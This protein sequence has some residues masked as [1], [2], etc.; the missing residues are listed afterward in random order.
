MIVI[1]EPGIG[2]SRLL[3]EFAARQRRR[4]DFLVGR[5]SPASTAIPFSVLAEALESR[6]RRWPVDKLR[7]LAEQR[8]PDLAHLL[9]SVDLAFGRGKDTPTRLRVLEALRAVLEALAAERPMVLLLDDLHQ[10]DRSSWEAL[11]YLARNPPAAHLLI[12][13]AIRPDELFGIPELVG[14]I[15]TLI[16]DGLAAE[17]RLPPLDQESVT[18]LTRR[19]LPETVDPETAAWLYG[20]AR[21]NALYTVALLDDLALDATRRVVPTGIQERVR[22]SLLDLPQTSRDVLEA[23][24]VMGHSFALSSILSLVP[25]VRAADLDRLVRRGLIV[26][27]RRTDEAGYNFVH[28]LVQEAIYSELGPARRRELHLALA[29]ALPVDALSARAY[30]AALGAAPG[31][32]DAVELLRAAA[33]Q[34]ERE[35]AHRDA[36]V[37]LERALAIAPAEPTPLRLELLDEIAWQAAAAGE[38]LAGIRALEALAPLVANDGEEAARTDVRLAS[39]LSTGAG[40]LAAAEK[41][42]ARA[43]RLLSSRPNSRTLAAAVNELAWIRGEAGSLADQVA[44]SRRAAEL[45]R[46]AGADDVRMHALGCLGHALALI[47]EFDEA[48]STL[49]ESLQLA[50]ASGDGGQVGWHTGGL[51]TALLLA[52]RD[53]DAIELLDRLLA[54]RANSSD[55]AYFSRALV[56]WHLGRWEPALAD[57]RQVQALNPNVPSVHSAWALSI[58][59]AVLAGQGRVEEARSFLAQAERVYEERPFYCFSAWHDWAT[60]HALWLLGDPTGARQR[61]ASALNRLESM[62]ADAAASQVRPDLWQVTRVLGQAAPPA[63]DLAPLRRARER[64][65]DGDLAEAA[66]IYATLPAPTQEQRVLARLRSQGPAG[67]RAARR[68]GSLTQR[69]RIVAALAASGLTDREI[70]ARLHVGDRTVETHLAHVYAKLKIAGRVE[71]RDSLRAPSPV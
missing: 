14:L 15:A 42:A 36:L 40:E 70:A 63:T 58:G 37:H 23:A 38:H 7:G 65:L 71:L 6:L 26:E 46:Q 60:G 53:G 10:A 51:A 59:G 1:G 45:A 16:K 5:G 57:V 2:K 69:E 22:M 12:A 18:S 28:P 49:G 4:A 20:R 19:M 21:G 56:N 35:E 52:G 41:H 68:S 64:E 30:H 24:A 43:V 32:L 8:L 29:G 44:E 48:V 55:V 50:R 33:R 13:A 27:S 11:N 47:G 25:D 54:P 61:F 39:F 17:L 31:D 9:P 3:Q 62:G 67:R 66:R 34:A